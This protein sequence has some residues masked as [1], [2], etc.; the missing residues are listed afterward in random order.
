MTTAT[1]FRLI[2][3]R[4][5][6]SGLAAMASATRPTPGVY[7]MDRSSRLR[8]GTFERISIL[9]PRCSRNVRSLTLWTITPE[10]PASAAT[11]ASACSVPEAAQVT[12]TRSR[13]LPPAVTSSAV[14]T[15]PTCSTARV[16]SLTARPREAT[17]SR[18]VIE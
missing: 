10:M 4:R 12:S 11:I 18:T 7:A 17:S 3:S 14:T 6:S 15:P 5:A 16:I 8:S 2:V 1:E 9:P 13:S